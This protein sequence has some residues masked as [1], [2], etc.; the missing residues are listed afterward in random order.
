MSYMETYRLWREK[1]RENEALYTELA[2]IEGDGREIE[3][4]FY[5]DLEF[6]TGGLWGINCTSS[7]P[8]RLCYT[9]FGGTVLW[10]SILFEICLPIPKMDG[11][12]R[13]IQHTSTRKRK[14]QCGWRRY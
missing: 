1:V 14:L 6:G 3:D 9:N 2:G 4:R 13:Y 10:R 12:G 11:D 8:Q 7:I 5:R